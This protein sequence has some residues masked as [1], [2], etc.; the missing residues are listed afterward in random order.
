MPL[1]ELILQNSLQIGAHQRLEA[2]FSSPFGDTHVPCHW[3]MSQWWV[4]DT[5]GGELT[6]CD[7]LLRPK[8]RAP[9]TVR[10]PGRA[11]GVRTEVTQ[12]QGT[13]KGSSHQCSSW[14]GAQ[15]LTPHEV[16][17]LSTVRETRQDFSVSQHQLLI[18]V[19]LC[20]GTPKDFTSV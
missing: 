13:G 1:E 4:R 11:R 16:L 14:P 8:P 12:A 18:T 15:P 2:C 3:E 19:S 6:C 20:C 7:V 10:G 9:S 17:H 5:G